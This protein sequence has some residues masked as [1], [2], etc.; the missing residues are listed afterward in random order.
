MKIRVNG[1]DEQ[2]D[3]GTTVAQVIQGLQEHDVNLIVE[4][5][6]RYVRPSLYGSTCLFDGDELEL[7]NPAFGG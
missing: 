5:N 7:I 4:L 1:F 3:E 2:W 6:R